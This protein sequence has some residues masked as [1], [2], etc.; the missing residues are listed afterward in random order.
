MPDEKEFEMPNDV[1][2]EENDDHPEP[3]SEAHEDKKQREHDAQADDREAPASTPGLPLC[4]Y[5]ADCVDGFTSAWVV[6]HAL[7]GR[8]ELQA[9]RYGD[10]LDPE[11]VVGRDLLIVDFSFPR[12]HMISLLDAAGKVVILDHHKT[13]AKALADL[14][15]KDTDVCVFD[16]DRSG[17]SLTWDVLMAGRPRPNL[18][19]YVEDR[20]LWR[21][22]LPWSREVSAFVH[23]FDHFVA[24]WDRLAAAL[25]Q[26]KVLA[27]CVMEGAGIDRQHKRTVTQL[28]NEYRRRMTIAGIS[29]WAA[30]APHAFASDL[31]HLLAED[32]PFAAVYWDTAAGRVFSLRSR[33]GG[34]DVA[35]VAEQFGGGGHARAAGFTL[36][37]RGDTLIIEPPVAAASTKK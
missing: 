29:V 30:N 9:F 25:D 36:H 6:H 5:H 18:V 20:D 4:V 10:G 22:H 8:V 26:P 31:G 33:P 21:F 23:S 15:L 12:K 13:A 11:D 37:V 1:I 24:L 32:A 35:A 27:D 16:M 14:P 19:R 17:A 7:Q 3:G 34:A 28:A 2:T